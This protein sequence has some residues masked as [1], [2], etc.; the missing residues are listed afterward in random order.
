MKYISNPPL[1]KINIFNLIVVHMNRLSSTFMIKNNL[2]RSSTFIPVRR[3]QFVIAMSFAILL[4][5]KSF[6]CQ[7]FPY[8]L[9]NAAQHQFSS[10]F[11][12]IAIHDIKLYLSFTVFFPHSF[13]RVFRTI[14]LIG[15]STR[16][17][18]LL[19]LQ[20]HFIQTFIVSC[21]RTEN[22]F[23]LMAISLPLHFFTIN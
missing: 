3:I 8:S 2:T 6:S 14:R 17:N 13:H 5:D 19:L 23:A 7:K 16:K 18:V 21:P 1:H 15:L 4:F 11:N 22:Y 9:N 10:P 12:R 20:H